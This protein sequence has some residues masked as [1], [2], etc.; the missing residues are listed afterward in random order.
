MNNNLKQF[1]YKF[2]INYYKDL[3]ENNIDTYEKAYQ[4]YKNHGLNENR[5][6]SAEHLLN[7]LKFNSF[8]YKSNYTDLVEMNDEELKRHFINHGIIENRIC[9]RLIVDN[10]KIKINTSKKNDELNLNKLFLKSINNYLNLP[11][12]N[13]VKN[14]NIGTVKNFFEINNENILNTLKKIQNKLDPKKE[15]VLTI[16]HSLY[17]SN[18]GGENW[19]IDMIKYTSNDYNNIG[20]CFRNVVEGKDFSNLNLVEL[21]FV[22]IIQMEYDLYLLI[23]IIKFFN[24][25]IINHQGYLR[26]EICKIS[27]LLNKIFITGFCFWNN[28][29]NLDE[30]NFNIDMIN[31]VYE[32]DKSFDEIYNHSN[33]YLASKFVSDIAE[34]VTNKKMEIIDSISHED[35]FL[36]NNN[37]TNKKYVSVLN[38]HFL[39]GGQELLYLLYNL[40]FN[41][42]LIGIITEISG[43]FDKKIIEGF[44]WRNQKNNINILFRNKI[45]N[46]KNIYQKS[47]IILVPSLVDETYCRVAYEAM[48]NNI[49]IISYRN[50]NLKYLLKD[51]KNNI[52]IENPL[53]NIGNYSNENICLGNNFL[54][55]WEEKIEELYFKD[56]EYIIDNYRKDETVKNKIIK[57]YKNSKIK[58][59]KNCIGIFCPF[60]DQGLG[61]QCREYYVFLKKLNYNVAVFSHKSYYATQSDKREWN[62]ENIYYSDNLRDEIKFE[63]VFQFC[64]KYKIETIIIPEIC[65]NFIYTIIKYFKILNVKVITPINI[66][67]FRYSEINNYDLIDII[68]ANNKS[69]FYILKEIFKN[70]EVKLL[71]FNN[72]YFIPTISKRNLRV[73][74]KIRFITFGGYNS[75]IRKNIDKTY[76]IFKKIEQIY[77]NFIL[78]IMIQSSNDKKKIN[79]LKDTKNIRIYY[80]NLNYQSI[81]SRIKESHICINLGD[82]EGLG[83][84]FF[85]ALNNNILLFTLNTFPNCEYV[86][87]GYNGFLVDYDSFSQLE[88]NNESIILKAN[89]NLKN[90]YNLIFNILHP[91]FRNKLIKMINNNKL[92][93]N[94]YEKNF[95]NILK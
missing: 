56:N 77:D 93:N 60:V 87:V 54:K 49:K 4:H 39:K 76:L 59:N 74:E 41:I 30:P 79:L 81:L 72:N 29:I 31:R 33:L 69:S 75:F 13:K 9:S 85:E 95:I 27:N 18:G 10:S 44:E 83:L 2:Y 28:L 64:Y 36:L 55:I 5:F 88:D 84:G 38:C 80:D 24:P 16:G 73:K 46:I 8:I 51:Y 78:E 19:L 86:K 15:L 53:V 21:D 26:I 92:I 62:Y 25:K 14:S 89:I 67:T 47:E 3:K 32:L 37:D 57:F 66:E 45:E 58:Y 65:Y 90:Y 52:F 40:N 50:G 22:D 63:E 17:P 70:K 7:K 1:D 82:H 6:I 61:I 42:P 43:E 23:N 91:N 48:R 12:Y 35:H 11:N 94:N 71:E 20:I 68:I 34:K